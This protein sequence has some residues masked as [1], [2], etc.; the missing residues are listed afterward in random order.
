MNHEALQYVHE[1]KTTCFLGRER[2]NGTLDSLYLG[3]EISE[4]E[5][6]ITPLGVGT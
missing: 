4:F 2:E 5:G 6:G 3:V 1:L